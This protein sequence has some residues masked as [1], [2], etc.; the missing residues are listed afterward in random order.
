MN[1]GMRGS[2]S[3]AASAA[4]GYLG[5]N[6]S[7]DIAI[8]KSFLKSK[9]LTASLSMNDMFRTRGYLQHSSSIYFTQDYYQLKDPQLVRLNLSW[10][11]GKMDMDLFKRKDIKSEM[12]N[13][14]NAQ[15][16]FGG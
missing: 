16:N 8:K 4:Q 12:D 14:K 6:G 10:R 13:M 3:M 2:M 15:D 1:S 5:A 11:F 9:A 7:V